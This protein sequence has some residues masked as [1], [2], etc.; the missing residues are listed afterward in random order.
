MGRIRKLNVCLH[1]GLSAD[2][3]HSE[4]SAEL[5]ELDYEEGVLDEAA[6]CASGNSTTISPLLGLVVDGVKINVFIRLPTGPT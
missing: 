3:S 6:V 1:V 5:Y 2:S 4:L